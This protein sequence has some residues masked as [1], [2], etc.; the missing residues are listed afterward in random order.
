M[1]SID[2]SVVNNAAAF[3]AGYFQ[4]LN[5]ILQAVDTEEVGRF[6]QTLLDA[7]D[8]D[9]TTFI[10]GNGGSAATASHMANDLTIGTRAHLRPFRVVSLTDNAAILTALG[11]DFGYDQIFVRQLR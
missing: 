5:A 8:R 10:I 9:A 2:S 7:R 6:I 1:T 3:T 11:N 4:R